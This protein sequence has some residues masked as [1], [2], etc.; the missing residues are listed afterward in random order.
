VTGPSVVASGAGL[1][2]ARA[3]SP[4]TPIAATHRRMALAAIL[5][6]AAA[7]R[8]WM[9][10][11]IVRLD[12]FRYVEVSHHVL[13]GG[14]LFDPSVF[15][16][17]SRL[18]MFG[19][20]IASN[21]ILGYGE[22][23]CVLFPLACSLGAVWVVYALGRELIDDR[24]GLLA[25][26]VMAVAP[27]EVELGTQLLPDTIEALF[28]PLAILLAV[29]A[30]RRDRRWAWWAFA[31]GVSLALAYFVRVNALVFLPGV[32]VVG[33]V[34]DPARW[35][36][37]LPVFAGLG[38]VVVLGALAFW[39]LSGDPFV[40]WTRTSQ[41]YST[42]QST[43]FLE[44]SA[45]YVWLMF[46]QGA[47]FWVGP[48]LLAGIA[49]AVHRKRRAETLLAVWAVGFLVYLDV[50][51]PMHGLASS[52][53]YLE[54]LVAPAVLLFASAALSVADRLRAVRGAKWGRAAV[55]TVCVLIALLV[56]PAR[57]VTRARRDNPRWA[58]VRSI[59][60][61]LTRD[62]ATDTVFVDD[63]YVLVA[64]DY[65]TGYS[66]GRDA[67]AAPDAP[68]NAGS[69]MFLTSE[70]APTSADSGVLVTVRGLPTPLLGMSVVAYPT[71][72]G[73]LTVWSL[74]AR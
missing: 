64:L 65:Y 5:G 71:P 32:L 15:Y 70:H 66:Y 43:G 24:V 62:H 19:P 30:V 50:V 9:F 60:G 17:S 6:L 46:R 2:K 10:V 54:P 49:W 57:I 40:D 22:W 74:R 45:P 56:V 1:R 61:M 13:S 58:S 68:A 20:L 4:T 16:A 72:D 34:L 55:L 28:V 8:A 29:L 44:R 35:R 11:G 31:S 73:Q 12:S 41:F 67:L 48:M 23:A 14:S 39:V 38:S 3:E 69:R 63:H 18:S 37:T 52:Y 53:R 33:A 47:V 7:L 51:S 42:Y 26:L 27:L 59:G 21:A 25:A 36:R